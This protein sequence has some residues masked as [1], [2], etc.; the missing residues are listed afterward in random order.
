MHH[1]TTYAN[2][3]FQYISLG[4]PVLGS[5]A[6]AQEKIIKKANAGLIHQDRDVKDF[7]NKV[8]ELY[9]NKDLREEFGKNGSEFIENEFSWENTSKKL[10]HVYTNL[11]N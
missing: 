1:D 3:I 10:L 11:K 5:N 6:S 7:S 8:L 2:K 4:R 9:N